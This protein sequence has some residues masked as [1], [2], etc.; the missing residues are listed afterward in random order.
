MKKFN[1]NFESNGEIRHKDQKEHK[2][3]GKKVHEQFGSKKHEKHEKHGSKKGDFGRH[4]DSMNRHQ[5]HHDGES[6]YDHEDVE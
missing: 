1:K 5:E 2:E 4:N 6:R 3:Q